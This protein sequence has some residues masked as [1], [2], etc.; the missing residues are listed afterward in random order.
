MHFKQLSNRFSLERVMG[1]INSPCI[2]LCQ[3]D[4]TGKYCAGC[5]R[6]MED[7]ISWYDMNNAEKR[8][9]LKRCKKNKRKDDQNEEL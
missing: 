1:E 8:R 5:F 4:Y 3:T 2:G 7:V 6:D 9:A